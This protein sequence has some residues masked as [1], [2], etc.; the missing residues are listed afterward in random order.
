MNNKGSSIIDV[1]FIGIVL[2]MLAIG[3]FVLNAIFDEANTKLQD[4]DSLSANSK[5]F[6]QDNQSKFPKTMDMLFLIIFAGL[7][8]SIFIGAFLLNTHPLFFI[9]T[10]IILAFFVIIAAILGNVYEEFTA[11]PV[12]SAVESSY[13]VIPFVMQ[14]FTM[15]I[16]G[17]GMLL[18]LGLFAKARG[19]PI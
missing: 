7:S 14:N 15:S 2:T 4:S 16:L 1:L 13:I 9:F 19:D 10:V 12:F 17:I 11:R 5:Q 18:L 3:I 8:I 6:S